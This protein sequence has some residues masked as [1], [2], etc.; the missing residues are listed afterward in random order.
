MARHE[1]SGTILRRLYD[2]PVFAAEVFDKVSTY[3]RTS[4]FFTAFRVFAALVSG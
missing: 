2:L 1:P 4:H 3:I